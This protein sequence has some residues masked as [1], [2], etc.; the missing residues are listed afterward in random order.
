MGRT[1][2]VGPTGRLGPRY[3]VKV[4][5][6]VADIERKL[7]QPHACPNCGALKLKRIG[8]SIWGCDRCGAKFAGGAYYP[9]R[10][11]PSGEDR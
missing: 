2:K 11:R 3:G 10:A 5:E 9:P 7:K 1:K 6:L 4:R 8:T